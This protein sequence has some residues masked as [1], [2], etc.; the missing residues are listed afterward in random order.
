M[1]TELKPHR[2][3]QVDFF[4]VQSPL[5]S[6]ATNVAS[7]SGEDGIIQPKSGSYPDAGRLVG[8]LNGPSV[9]AILSLT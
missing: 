5:L 4:S 6:Y 7:Q 3:E 8:G 9:D 2:L 1:N